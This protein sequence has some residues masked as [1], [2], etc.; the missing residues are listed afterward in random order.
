MNEIL[1]KILDWPF[2]LFLGA[3]LLIYSFK[4]EFGKILSRGVINLTWGNKSFEISEL[5]DQFQASSILR[6]MSEVV[7]SRAKSGR[8]IVKLA[9][10]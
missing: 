5:P 8:T 3:G 1:L 2:L 4:D 6:E 9:D 10:R 7:F